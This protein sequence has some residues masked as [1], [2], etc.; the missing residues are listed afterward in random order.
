MSC[1]SKTVRKPTSVGGT[2]NDETAISA[3]I[4][5]E[6]RAFME[7]D[8]KAWGR[9]RVQ[10]G[11]AKAVSVTPTT[12]LDV[13]SGWNEIVHEMEHVMQH[14]LGCDMVQF[15]KSNLRTQIEGRIAW[16]VYEQ[17]AQNSSG[18][19]WETF[20]T[21]ILERSPDG[22]KIVY[23]SFVDPGRSANS[24]GMM[25]V[26]KSGHIIWAS[27]ETLERLRD[28]PVL[29]VS[30]GRVRARRQYWDRV[31][32]SAISQAARY[33]GF[34]QLRRFSDE[35]GGPFHFP[36]VLGETDDGGIAVIQV[37][38]RDSSTY[39]EFDGAQS[40]DRRLSIAQ[41]VFG[42]SD[43]QCRV[44]R[45]IADGSGP[46]GAAEALG[47]SINTARTHLTRLYEKTGVNS[48]AALVR[49]L[50]SVG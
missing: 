5:A 43:G 41:A 3:V 37:L 44:A 13:K 10:E 22:W 21:R 42:L 39:L 4:H 32:Q 45:Y 28:H 47:I 38:V 11:R 24:Q 36:A 48:Q 29:T 6:T 33:H 15:K 50:L 18:A 49:I 14:G 17:W 31:L 30:A 25:S 9:C 7:D 2:T 26:D 23:S 16:A 34:Y 1:M 19:T 46:K 8:L 27:P 35:T 12:G 20:E 40:I